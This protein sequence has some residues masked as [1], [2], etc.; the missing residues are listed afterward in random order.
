MWHT[1]N[2]LIVS[3]VVVD[4][5]NTFAVPSKQWSNCWF[6]YSSYMVSAQWK[7]YFTVQFPQVHHNKCVSAHQVHRSL[8][9]LLGG[10]RWTGM[11]VSFWE[12]LVFQRSKTHTNLKQQTV[13]S[14]VTEKNYLG[15]PEKREKFRLKSIWGRFL[16]KSG[17]EESFEGHQEQ[18]VGYGGWKKAELQ[19]SPHC[20]PQLI[21]TY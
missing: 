8:W 18:M 9:Q 20:S 2:I 17:T 19:N 1:L 13:H 14:K 4:M 11:V 15:A 21:E 7:T 16:E 10:Q 6:A 5:S 12:L 3:K